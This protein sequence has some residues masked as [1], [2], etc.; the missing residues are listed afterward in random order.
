MALF[1]GREVARIDGGM[2]DGTGNGVGR[3]GL[4]RSASKGT[5]SPWKDRSNDDP[6]TGSVVPVSSVER[7]LEVEPLC[8]GKSP[9]VPPGRRPN[10]ERMQGRESGFTSVSRFE[11]TIAR[12]KTLN[13]FGRSEGSN[14]AGSVRCAVGSDVDGA[15]THGSGG[16]P[17]RIPFGGAGSSAGH[18][19]S[20]VRNGSRKSLD[21]D[22]R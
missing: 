9:A 17:S 5:R 1:F 22:R 21:S 18:A 12:T 4:N 13:G 7:G 8:I 15:G 2:S 19:L 3:R 6:E 20:V 11:G 10:A 14:P 16:I